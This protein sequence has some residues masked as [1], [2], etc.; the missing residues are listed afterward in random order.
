MLALVRERQETGIW[1]EEGRNYA[2][3]GFAWPSEVVIEFGERRGWERPV[4]TG[5]GRA[6]NRWQKAE[7]Q[8]GG[9]KYRW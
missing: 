9:E 7:S 4:F 6:D 2:R 1:D 5:T 8:S 3:K